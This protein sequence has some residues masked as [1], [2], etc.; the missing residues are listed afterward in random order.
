VSAHTVSREPSEFSEFSEFKISPSPR[1]RGLGE[2]VL[3]LE[4]LHPTPPLTLRAP[5]RN[6]HNARPRGRES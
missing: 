3:E 2:G 4:A 6:R 1:G 5:P